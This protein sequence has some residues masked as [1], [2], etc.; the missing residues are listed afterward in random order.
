MYAWFNHCLRVVSL[1]LRWCQSYL[2]MK[3]YVSI[4]HYIPIILTHSIFLHVQMYITYR[5]ASV[6]ID[7]KLTT[8]AYFCDTHS[9]LL[10][11]NQSINKYRIFICF[12]FWYFVDSNK[13]E[14]VILKSSIYNTSL[15]LDIKCI[16]LNRNFLYIIN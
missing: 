6:R 1:L 15:I 2:Y 12:L 3:F 4:L 11:N 16:R 9:F 5:C 14:L 8:N 13:N 7:W 10:S